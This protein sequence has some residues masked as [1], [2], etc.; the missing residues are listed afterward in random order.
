MNKIIVHN[1]AKIQKG[2][3]RNRWWETKEF[4]TAWEAEKYLHEC[5]EEHTCT[6][7]YTYCES[8]EIGRDISAER[9]HAFVAAYAERMWRT[10]G[11]F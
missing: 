5:Q 3:G 6:A 2:Y 9:S 1:Y 10:G 7:G 8:E 11:P 4:P